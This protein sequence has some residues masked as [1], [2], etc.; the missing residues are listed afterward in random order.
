MS[1]AI[2]FSAI[3]SS[4]GA[5][6]LLGSKRPT[7]IMSANKGVRGAKVKTMDPLVRSAN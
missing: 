7:E 3:G 2:L 5:R 1:W 6:S 4:H